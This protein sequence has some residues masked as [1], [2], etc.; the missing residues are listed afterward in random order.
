[1]PSHITRA[2]LSA[3][4]AV[5]LLL[6]AALSQP[7]AA[8]A[9]AP[10]ALH[11]QNPHYFLFRGQPAILITSGEHYG[12]VVNL[13]FDYVKY[14]D[15]LAA[16]RLNLTRLFVAYR[17]QP[18]AFNIASNTLAPQQE[19]FIAPWARSGVPGYFDGGN[20]FD[21][22]KWDEKYFARLRDFVAEAAKRGVIVEATLFSHFYG[23]KSWETHPLHPRNNVN[24]VGKQCTWAEAITLKH[25]DVVAAQEAYVRKV[26]AEL[27]D[28]DN[29]YYEVC[30][31]PYAH[32]VTANDEI[33]AWQ[34]RIVDVIVDAE[35][36][37]P[38]RHLISL[39]VS[40][41]ESKVVNP[42]PAVSIFNFH[43]AYP[44][45]AVEMNYGLNKA[46]GDNETGFNGNSDAAYRME[47]WDFI[48]A[49]GALYNNL[50]Y[51]FAVGHEDGTFAYPATQPG[52][53]TVALRR[54]LR[55]LGD[56][57]R[58]FDF[59]RMRPDN[60][61][62]KSAP[63]GRTARA[64]VEPGKAYAVYIRTP[65]FGQYSARW[66]GFIVPKF[67]EEYAFHTVSNDG[68][69]LWVNGQQV[70]NNWTDHS[71][72]EDV[73]KIKLEAGRRYDIKLEYF[74]AGGQAT[75]KLLWSSRSQPKEVV[76]QSQL[77]SPGGG[78]GLRGEYFKDAWLQSPA[79]TRDDAS[80][81]FEWG[82]ASPFAAPREASSDAALTLEL[83][84][85]AYTAEWVDTKLGTVARAERFRHGGGAKNL[86]APAFA[87][88]IALRVKR[89]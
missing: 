30:N 65:V 19:R 63:A 11:P 15:T 14:L 51:S 23:D 73:G 36:N 45:T 53:G 9:R 3:A 38:H 81:N 43:Y 6:P 52:G 10:L 46:I 62:I 47:G 8:Q 32:A 49:G 12:A 70:I 5:S 17:E 71:A 54:Q 77:L 1:M 40:N 39:N 59:I 68:V 88:D 25:A 86:T 82:A 78:R 2:L 29:V 16:D 83:P 44:P 4:C 66:T 69:R 31:E 64:L 26:V 76:P 41:H 56:F 24:G 57:M 37:F 79:M 58:G 67:S 60:S 34:H 61:V 27:R 50:D 13:D 75:M 85:G 20:K 22:T 87:D 35:K 28:F 72:T 84:A 89:Q 48:V 42:H 55:H 74:Y 7:C 18:G 21:L 80:V 33:M